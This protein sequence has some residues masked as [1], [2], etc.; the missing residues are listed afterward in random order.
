MINKL[1]DILEEGEKEFNKEVFDTFCGIIENGG[2]TQGK[3]YINSWFVAQQHKL[4]Q[5]IVEGIETELENVTDDFGDIY[6][7]FPAKEAA[8]I[9]KNRIKNTLSD[10][11]S[12]LL[13]LY[14]R[15]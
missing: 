1:Q 8:I 3:E 9:I 10:L 7:K 5:S 11:K 15:K 14:Y 6:S 2:D 13:E 4:L 12:K